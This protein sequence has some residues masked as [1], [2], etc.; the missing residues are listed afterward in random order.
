MLDTVR[1]CA[2]RQNHQLV[3]I[4]PA[5][6]NEPAMTE[7]FMEQLR[8]E[9]ALGLM[10]T[11]SR[12][13]ANT[14]K[15]LEVTAFSYA[16]I[17]LLIERG[18]ISV[19]ELDERKR[20]LGEALLDKF[21]SKGMGVLV[22]KDEADK[23][24]YQ[25]SVTIDC[26]NRRHLC[27]AACCRLR[28]ALS[29]QDLEEG[30]VRWDLGHPYMIRHSPDGYCH[31][32]DRESG[33]CG[34]YANRPLTCRSYDCRHDERIWENFEKRIPSPKLRELLPELET[35]DQEAPITI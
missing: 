9:L 22:L 12:A 24:N 32:L 34:V 14:S 7:T 33:H 19:E 5:G 31:H 10:Y 15:M 20:K 3:Q 25:G 29:I 13:N 27:H 11:H 1:E 17:E 16:L 8:D 30:K 4:Q 26:E 23:Y 6:P 21:N 35:V 2:G 28:F 18:V